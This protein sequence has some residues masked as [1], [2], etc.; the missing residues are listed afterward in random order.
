MLLFEQAT[1]IESPLAEDGLLRKLKQSIEASMPPGTVALRMAVTSSNSKKWDIDVGAIANLPTDSFQRFDILESTHRPKSGSGFNVALVIPTGVGSELGGHAG[2]AG[3]TAK[4]MG[5]LCDTLITHPNVVNASDINEMPENGLY[6]EG[7]ILS[8]FL[9]GTI[10]LRPVRSNRVLVVVDDH[11]NQLF[12]SAAINSVNAAC[13]TYG[14]DC[15]GGLTMSP[16][17]KLRARFSPSGRAAGRVEGLSDLVQALDERRDEFDAVAIA[18]VIDVP[19]EFH[20]EYF[21][22]AGEMINPWGGVEAM[23]THAIS[24]L[25]DVPSAH[26]PMFESEDIAN[27]DVGIVDPRMAAEAV[28]MTFLQCVLK[29]LATAPAIVTEEAAIAR[30]GVLTA[31]DVSCLVIPDGCIGLPTL[32]ALEQGIPV[33]AVAEAANIMKNDLEQ[34]PWRPGQLHKATTMLEAAGLI[35]ALRSG[36]SPASVRRPIGLVSVERLVVTVAESAVD[37]PSAKV[38][39][40]ADNSA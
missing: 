7:S 2:D 24:T 21:E 6:V 34:L 30:P 13:A 33:I 9:L 26:S 10:G 40:V 38:T 25:L 17:V 27:M 18:S 15:A 5:S 11:Q 29:G 39:S 22:K 1:E 20:R 16:G 8:R 12:T 36:V 14:L 23:L 28:S 19:H 32:A 31:G 37:E 4:L 35:A 3:P